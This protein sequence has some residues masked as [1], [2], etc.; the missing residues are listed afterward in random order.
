MG[1]LKPAD[2][3]ADTSSNILL[4]LRSRPAS[5]RHPYRWLSLLAMACGASATAVAGG[6]RRAGIVATESSESDATPWINV[7]LNASIDGW[8]HPSLPIYVGARLDGKGDASFDPFFATSVLTDYTNVS[9]SIPAAACFAQGPGPNFLSV[10]YDEGEGGNRQLGLIN[11]DHASFTLTAMAQLGPPASPWCQLVA[12]ESHD[13]VYRDAGHIMS[14][15]VNASHALPLGRVKLASNQHD[16]MG[17][18]MKGWLPSYTPQ[19]NQTYLTM[20]GHEPLGD[21]VFRQFSTKNTSAVRQSRRLPFDFCT[22]TPLSGMTMSLPTRPSATGTIIAEANGH[23]TRIHFLGFDDNPWGRNRFTHREIT[24]PSPYGSLLLQKRSIGRGFYADFSLYPDGLEKFSD[25]RKPTGLVVLNWNRDDS[26]ILSYTSHPHTPSRVMIDYE[27]FLCMG[28]GQGG[29]SYF[30][31]LTPRACS[32]TLPGWHA[33]TRL[34]NVIY[35][36]S[37]LYTGKNG[38][39]GVRA[40]RRS[41]QTR[42]NCTTVD[43]DTRQTGRDP[44]ITT[45]G[46]LHT[47]GISDGAPYHHHDESLGPARQFCGLPPLPT[48]TPSP[49]PTSTPM[50]TAEPSSHGDKS[51]Q[52]TVVTLGGQQT[53]SRSA[54]LWGAAT[55]STA[56]AA[57]ASCLFDR[58]RRPQRPE[59]AAAP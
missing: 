37:F 50:P 33:S 47:L 39:T 45:M 59:G 54:L 12:T 5:G 11:M 41:S 7:T 8:P 1:H 9:F 3:R 28:S 26:G 25:I 20:V 48:P 49:I 4:W 10:A 55:L 13:I 38:L 16:F 36:N 31:G 42:L 17:A 44:N 24:A 46:L 14:F 27:A 19:P 6:S 23:R 34:P 32:D 2:S 30:A 57:T 43:T 52:A 58:C 56:V 51:H 35:G 53:P 18:A 29:Y 40:T 15:A 21:T 22:G